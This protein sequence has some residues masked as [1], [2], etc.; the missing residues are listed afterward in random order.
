MSQVVSNSKVE[1]KT[2]KMADLSF[3]PKLFVPM[4]T[5]TRIDEFFSAKRGILPGTNYVCAGDPGVGKTTVLLDVLAELNEAGYK[6]LFISGE[7]D[8]FDM[9]AYCERFPKFNKV[10][11]LFMGQYV[12]DEDGIAMDPL[13]IMDEALS[14]GYDVVLADSMKELQDIVTEFHGGT[15]TSS[16]TKVL[17][18]FRKHN[19]ASNIAKLYT[20]FLIIQQVTKS[21]A[22]A[23][24]NKLKHMTTGMMHMKLNSDGT[25][26]LFFSKNRRGGN[27]NGLFFNLR[28]EDGNVQY[29]GELTL[30]D[31]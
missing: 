22:A 17:N 11:T 6:T 24:S 3:D 9:Y 23:G 5:G 12:D 28:G 20:S 13:E 25:R 1:V 26:H 31:L 16:L 8:K 15:G 14:E 19:Q 30:N 18:L 10:E 7:M 27:G 29:T 4:A 21:G 2:V